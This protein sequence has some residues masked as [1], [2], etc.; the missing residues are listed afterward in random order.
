MESMILY[1]LPCRLC[2]GV[3]EEKGV[4]ISSTVAKEKLSE[5]WQL[6]LGTQLEYEDRLEQEVWICYSCTLKSQ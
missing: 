3:A 1:Q 5:W 4:R 2:E 6:H